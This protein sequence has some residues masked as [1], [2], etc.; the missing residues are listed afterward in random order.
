MTIRLMRKM[1]IMHFENTGLLWFTPENCKATGMRNKALTKFL[2][3]TAVMVAITPAVQAAK[4]R[5]S[6]TP[7]P[8]VVDTTTQKPVIS[9]L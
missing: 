2:L 9:A 3:L 5:P 4:R 7:P 8:P 1:Q 6:A